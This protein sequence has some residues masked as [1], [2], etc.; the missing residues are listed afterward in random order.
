MSKGQ[1]VGLHWNRIAPLQS[2]YALRTFA[3]KFSNI[4]FFLKILPLKD[5]ELVMSEI[6][7]KRGVTDFVL[8]R[9]CPEKHLNLSKSGFVSKEGH[10]GCKSPNIAIRALK[11][12]VLCQIWFKWTYKANLV[13]WRGSSK[14]KFPFSDHNFTRLAPA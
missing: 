6:L 8:E 3:R 5:D 7:K 10:S 12:N 11:G 14:N 13:N 1:F 4:D 2:I 9:T